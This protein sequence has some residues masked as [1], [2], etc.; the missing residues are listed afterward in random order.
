MRKIGIAILGLGAFYLFING[1]SNEEAAV[2]LT[3][4][5]VFYAAITV[6][7]LWE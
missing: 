5:M 7:L 4:A 6:F 2:V 1:R 3:T